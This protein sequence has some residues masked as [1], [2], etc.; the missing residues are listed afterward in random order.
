LQLLG[1]ITSMSEGE[2]NHKK[3]GAGMA[4]QDVTNQTTRCSNLAKLL[5]YQQML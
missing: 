4:R 5:F 2:I 1:A 3:V